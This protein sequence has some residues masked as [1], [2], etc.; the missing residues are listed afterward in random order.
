MDTP[1]NAPVSWAA[2]KGQGI[3]LAR[4]LLVADEIHSGRLLR[5]FDISVA[6]RNSYYFVCSNGRETE[7]KIQLL[8]DWLRHEV[9]AVPGARLAAVVVSARRSQT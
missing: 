5:L 2:I 4:S 7:E 1:S 6:S 9:V 8:L 3:T